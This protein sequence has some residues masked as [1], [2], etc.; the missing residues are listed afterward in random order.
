MFFSV[1]SLGTPTGPAGLLLQLGNHRP[2]WPKMICAN[3]QTVN[4]IYNQWKDVFSIRTNVYVYTY[5]YLFIYLFKY[6]NTYTYIYTVCVY[7]IYICVCV[8]FH[9]RYAVRL[10]HTSAATNPKPVA[11]FTF[12]VRNSHWSLFSAIGRRRWIY[13]ISGSIIPLF[14]SGGGKLFELCNGEMLVKR[15]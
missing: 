2:K 5:M 6:I 13:N 12:G 11:Y 14:H 7:Y 4:P 3:A 10:N 9:K 1:I 8:C 15:M